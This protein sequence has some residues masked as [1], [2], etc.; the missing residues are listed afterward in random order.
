MAAESA[1]EIEILE[2]CLLLQLL[3]I[4]VSQKVSLVEQYWVVCFVCKVNSNSIASM[5]LN[6]LLWRCVYFFLVRCCLVSERVSLVVLPR[7]L[8]WCVG[9][10]SLPGQ[11]SQ[12]RK[13]ILKLSVTQHARLRI[14]RVSCWNRSKR[15]Q[16][17]RRRELHNEAY[18]VLI[19]PAR[20][21]RVR[22]PVAVRVLPPAGAVRRAAIFPAPHAAMGLGR[23][24]GA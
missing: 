11:F 4:L 7:L 24:P 13:Q 12:Q 5:Q 21:Q 22:R 19:K 6:C 9:S 14:L 20:R 23:G 10:C 8:L 15:I 1:E 17:Q 3:W 2:I 16:S 18:H